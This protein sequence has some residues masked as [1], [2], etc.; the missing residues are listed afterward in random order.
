MIKRLNT[1]GFFFKF[2]LLYVPVKIFQSC[3]DRSSWVE[4]VLSLAQGHNTVTSLEL[5]NLQSTVYRSTDL[6]TALRLQYMSRNMR[7]QTMWHFDRCRL[8]Q[9]CAAYFKLRNSKCCSVS[10]RIFKQLAKAL[11]RLLVAHTTLLEISCRGHIGLFSKCC[12]LE[13]TFNELMFNMISI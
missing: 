2:E 5:A 12:L 11:I 10:S 7:F 8:R 13:F 3:Q 6:A 4:P 1:E 9:A